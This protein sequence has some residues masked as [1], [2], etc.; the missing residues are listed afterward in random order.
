MLMA[1][2]RYN[3]IK[4]AEIGVAYGSSVF[5]W[6]KYFEKGSFFFFDRDQNFL[7]HCASNVD[8]SR[9]SFSLMDVANSESIRSSLEAIGGS[10]DILLDDSS[11]DYKHQDLIIH[12]AL[13]L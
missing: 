10:L 4:F 12:E 8:A 2:Y 11:H 3:P 7:D 5:M 9:N 6:N 1:Q 13:P